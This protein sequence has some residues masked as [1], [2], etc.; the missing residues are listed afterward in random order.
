MQGAACGQCNLG[1]IYKD[2]TGVIKDYNK[3][4][5]WFEKAAN[6]NDGEAQHYLGLLYLLG[7]GTEKDVHKGKAWLEKSCKN[8][9]QKACDT[10]YKIQQ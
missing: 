2:G 7:Y 5:E 9:Y 8:E 10:L 1:I 4:F 6:Q 3:A